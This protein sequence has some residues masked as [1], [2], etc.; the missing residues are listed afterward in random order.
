MF[1]NLNAGD[2]TK[3]T[4]VADHEPSGGA[5]GVVSHHRAQAHG[6]G[7]S[8]KQVHGV[9]GP[10]APVRGR[11]RAG[12]RRR[13]V[14]PVER[15]R[16]LRW[17]DRGADAFGL[18]HKRARNRGIPRLRQSRR[19]GEVDLAGEQSAPPGSR[20]RY[21]LQPVRWRE[22]PRSGHGEP[23][24]RRRTVRSRLCRQRQHRR[25][26]VTVRSTG[27]R[28]STGTTRSTR[29][30]RSSPAVTASSSAIRAGC[31]SISGRTSG[32]ISIS[33][34]ASTTPFPIRSR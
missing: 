31:S 30:R 14:P 18:R 5:G 23:D 2:P 16:G 10:A 6:A 15:R 7:D 24:P 1:A 19:A 22:D 13:R 27:S 26:D 20:V 25:T 21:V 12:I 17:I 33:S 29:R 4:Y 34:I 32:T 8:A 11:R 28:T 3:W 9:L